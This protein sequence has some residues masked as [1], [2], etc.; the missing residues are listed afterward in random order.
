METQSGNRVHAYILAQ[1]NSDVWLRP[2]DDVDP[3]LVYRVSKDSVSNLSGNWESFPINVN[4]EPSP[5]PKTFTAPNETNV[6]IIGK[7]E[8]G[9]IFTLGGDSDN[10]RY[11][12]LAHMDEQSQALLAT[13]PS[14]FSFFPV[15]QQRAPTPEPAVNPAG[16]SLG[17]GE[18]WVRNARERI[19][20]N[21]NRV[22]DLH[23]QMSRSGVDQATRRSYMR[24][25]QDLER[26][27][28]RLREELNRRSN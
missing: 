9:A 11:G 22:R 25:I 12:Y 4:R 24:Q 19:T 3:Y 2:L 5:F 28:R 23:Q 14:S 20:Q 10:Y 13:L 18:A 16:E 8:L 21:Q 15:T 27:N 17:A 7:D 6:T 1:S 26:E